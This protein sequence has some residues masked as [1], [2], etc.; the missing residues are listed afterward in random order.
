MKIWKKISN[1]GVKKDMTSLLQRRII[2]TNQIS[3]IL[4]TLLFLKI[5]VLSIKLQ[6]FA[7]ASVLFVLFLFLLFVPFL[8][9]KGFINITRFIISIMLPIIIVAAST[10]GRIASETGKDIV[11][12]L[13]PIVLIIA[14]LVV[15]LILIDYRK[16]GYFLLTL[17]VYFICLASYNKLQSMLGVGIEHANLE[18]N[19][20]FIATWISIL[21]FLLLIISFIFFQKINYKYENKLQKQNDK[22]IE[23]ND[24]IS[25]AYEEIQA[26]EEELRQNSEELLAL[27]EN[28]TESNNLVVEKNEKLELQNSA[29][30]EQ[31][32]QIKDS[33]RYAKS[34]QKAVLPFFDEIRKKFKIFIIYKAK[35]IVSGDFI[36]HLNFQK[37][38]VDFIAMV[39]CTGHGVPGAFMSIIASRLLHKIITE[40]NITRTD[41]ILTQLNNEIIIALKQEQTEN[42]DGLD[43]SLCKVIRNSEGAKIEFSGAKLPIFYYKKNDAKM[44]RLKAD[45]IHIGG[46]IFKRNKRE[47]TVTEFQLKNNDMLYMATDGYIDQ[48]NFDRKRIGTQRFFDTLTKITE[49][50]L[51][52]QKEILISELENWQQKCKQRDDITLLGIRI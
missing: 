8:N 19:T 7:N 52:E 23:Q 26:A 12:H 30:E 32:K 40:Q 47:F 48:H 17:F 44:V 13:V 37:E 20:Y 1:L 45:S 9:K 6:L 21:A 50:P 35:D 15:P 22:L 4:A 39:D 14:S 31:A 18:T 46:V 28:L 5:L 41:K 33:I 27:N 11:F 42:M 49:K 10:Y 43:I 3:I 51:P 24:K 38:N 2:L 36:W 16:K 29:I 34:I 25:T